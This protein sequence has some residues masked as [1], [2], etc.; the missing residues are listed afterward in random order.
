VSNKRKL[1]GLAALVTLIWINASWSEAAT[2]KVRRIGSPATAFYLPPLK[3]QDDLR[4]MI[5]IRKADIQKVLVSRGWTGNIDDLVN[6]AQTGTIMET[7]IA[8]GAQLPFMAYRRG[9][10][11]GTIVDVTWVGAKPF[12]AFYFDF[13][14]GGAGYRVY[15]PK[16]CSNFWI[17]SRAI[18]K[19]PEPPPPPAPAPP[20]PPAPAPAPAP[21]VETP[22][23]PAPVVEPEVYHPW[24]VGGFVGKQRLTPDLEDVDNIEDLEGLC[25]ALIAAKVGYLP[26]LGHNLEAEL[27]V[28]FKLN[29][30]ETSNS[31]IFI[32]AALNA[33][34]H[35]GFVG[36]GV[37]FWD[38]TEEETRS[39]ALLLQF[40]FNLAPNERWQFVAEGRIPFDQFDDVGNNYQ[41][42]GGFRFRP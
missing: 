26:R 36:G 21:A 32:D 19:A 23:P 41:I 33:V 9:G 27:S 29:L 2:H 35:S 42:W 16:P 38:L 11:A 31:S 12:E 8:T 15:V 18:A 1:I 14:S 17:E 30:E 40:G 24:F 10:K 3:S 37:S 22:P 20:P 5:N 13:E 34:F 25:A 28:G 4:K 7:T 6:A 39:V